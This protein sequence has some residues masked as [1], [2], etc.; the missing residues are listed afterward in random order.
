MT[1]TT[2]TGKPLPASLTRSAQT[3]A[4]DAMSRRE[5]MATACTFG[6]SAATAYAMMGLPTPAEAASHAQMGGTVRIQQEIVTMRDPRKFDFNSLA[7]YTRGW[8]EYLVQ[9]NSD[10]SFSPVLLESW[11]ISEDA[12]TYTLRLR[13]GVTWNN[14]DPFTASDVAFNIERFADGTAEANAM[15]L[16]FAVLQD[17]QTQML[18]EGTVEIVDDHTVVLN[19]PRPDISLIAGLADYPAAIVHPSFTEDDMLTNPI[20]T[21]P[22]LPE[23]YEVG[24]SASLVRNADHTWWNAGNGAWMDRIEMIDFG[25]DP[26]SHFAAAEADEYD[27]AYDT[28]GDYITAFEALDDWTKH[29]VNT[30]AAVLARTNQLAEEGGKQ[31]YADV[32]VR[33]ALALAVD[34]ATILELAYSGLGALGEN[35]HVAPVHP[36]YADIGAPVRDV[37]AAMALLEEAGMADYEFE[38]ISLDAAFWKSTGDAIAGQLRDAGLN[39]RRT[40]YP[41]NTFWN[42]WAKYPFSITNWN[43]RPLGIQTYALAYKS[44]VSWNE[45]GF[46]NA[47]F[48]ALVDEAMSIAD[49][50]ERRKIMAKLEQIM[51]DEGVIIQPYWRGLAN[52]TKSNLKGAEIHI[53]QELYPQYMYW[54]A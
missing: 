52:F 36:D 37:D 17:P 35:H 28:E 22:Y 51:V 13:K 14:G 5:F 47:E 53:S 16:K 8:L 45:T 4:S 32:R 44:G 20:G 40:V 23:T 11:D 41:S 39:V 25:S 49:P 18:M 2:R 7:T 43:H 33:R 38:L 29:T 48:D 21:G 34:N 6:A 50:D 31:P 24:V 9:Y 30:A 15:A 10:G 1:F 26:A 46:A 19:L 3:A 54:E 42:D 12:K 27:V